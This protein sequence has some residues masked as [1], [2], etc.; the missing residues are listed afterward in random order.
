MQTQGARARKRL[1]PFAWASLAA[2]V[3]IA[4]PTLHAT[5]TGGLDELGCE[6]KWAQTPLCVERARALDARA[7]IEAVLPSLAR[8]PRPPWGLADHAAAQALYDEGLALFREEYFGD[9]A[10]KFEPALEALLAIKREYGQLVADAVAEAQGLL[11]KE[12]FSGALDTFTEILTAWEPNHPE[13]TA[14]AE[15]A[16]RRQDASR[17]AAEAIALVNAGQP[18]RARALLGSIAPDAAATA[19]DT[20]RRALHDYEARRR[21]N[22]QIT[23]GHAALDGQDL[24]AAAK[25]FR[26]ALA[27][28]PD[29]AAAKDGLANVLQQI[30]AN[31][32]ASLRLALADQLA[33]E[34]WTD[35]VAS[36]RE[37]S[38]LE[39]TADEVRLRL[40]ELVRLVEL[41]SRLDSALAHPE[42]AAAKTLRDETRA[43]VESTRDP[44]RVGRRIHA[45]G[46][47]LARRFSEWTASIPLTI[48]S[49]N[50]TEIHIRPGRRLGKFRTTELEVFPG[51][52]SLVARRAGFRE[53]RVELTVAP[54]S[55]PIVLELVCNERF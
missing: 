36:I 14:G 43:V 40:P 6:G 55:D 44:V 29:S 21:L 27:A 28:D 16:R 37:I 2:M 24:E 52:Y 30:D 38:T 50:K 34:S 26:A 20:A 42:R 39:P 11:A 9:A 23:A 45:K 19:V 10:A 51:R 22:A 4:A 25:A 17:L 31:R 7:K 33:N 1:P 18:Q 12:D 32:L 5:A 49:D 54:D 13:A 3:A 8:V 41:E 53:R 48:R 35:A 46:D 47:Q 15:Q